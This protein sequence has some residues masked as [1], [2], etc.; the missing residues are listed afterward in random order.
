M[1]ASH[2]YEINS[3]SVSYKLYTEKKTSAAHPGKSSAPREELNGEM[4][5]LDVSCR[6][7]KPSSE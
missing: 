7:N 2:N 6:E 3:N 4:L 1:P 5:L